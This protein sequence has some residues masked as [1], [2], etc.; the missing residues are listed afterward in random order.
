MLIFK[1]SGTGYA[2]LHIVILSIFCLFPSCVVDASLKRS[3]VILKVII[4]NTLFLT[5]RRHIRI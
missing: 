1:Y 2:S 5:W 4:N 3:G